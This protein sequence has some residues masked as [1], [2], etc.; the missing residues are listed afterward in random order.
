MRFKHVLLEVYCDCKKGNKDHCIKGM[1]SPGVH[2]FAE[3]C[4]FLSYTKCPNE[5]SYSGEEGIVEELDDFVGFGGNMGTEPYNEKVEK[6]LISKWK[7]ICVNK[8][9][10]A[11]KEFM[12]YKSHRY[13]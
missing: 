12:E 3:N 6:E 7:D 11:N 1:K 10:E 2:C 5:I 4:K 8:I 13:K 9:W